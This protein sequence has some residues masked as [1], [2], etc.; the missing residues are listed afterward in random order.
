MPV[1]TETQ[2]PKLFCAPVSP[3]LSEG[4]PWLPLIHTRETQ[5][6][7]LC[8]TESLPEFRISISVGAQSH[9]ARTYPMPPRG[10]T[11]PNLL[12]SVLGLRRLSSLPLHQHGLGPGPRLHGV[13]VTCTWPRVRL[14]RWPLTPGCHC[15]PPPPDTA[16]LIFLTQVPISQNCLLS[17]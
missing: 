3:P 13:L 1:C 7:L 2:Q 9:E 10:V 14:C 12:G 4:C 15:C 6:H 17:L 8:P 16:T 11:R 5:T